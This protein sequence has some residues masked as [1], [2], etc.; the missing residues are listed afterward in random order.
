[1]RVRSDGSVVSE[2]MMKKQPTAY[3]W[4]PLPGKIVIGCSSIHSSFPSW[5]P[6]VPESSTV[7]DGEQQ[8]GECYAPKAVK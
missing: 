3:E 1:M 2:D 4:C 7:D 8:I 5:P 6:H